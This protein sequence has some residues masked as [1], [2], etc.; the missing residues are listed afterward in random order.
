MQLVYAERLSSDQGVSRANLRVAKATDTYILAGRGSKLGTLGGEETYEPHFTYHGF[1]YVELVAS[2]NVHVESLIGIAVRTA[3]GE[4]TDL[5]TSD[6]RVNRLWQIVKWSLRANLMSVPTD[7]PQRS[8]R[9]GWL[10][11]AG[12]FWPTAVYL[13]DLKEF[14]R[15]WAQDLRDA[16]QGLRDAAAEGTIEGNVPDRAAFGCYPPFAPPPIAECGGPGWSDAGV[17]VPYAS[18]LQYGDAT[19]LRQHWASMQSYM[20]FIAKANP[21]FTWIEDNRGYGDWRAPFDEP[22]A[23]AVIGTA[24]WAADALAMRTMAH[25]LG[26]GRDEAIYAR[27]YERIRRAFGRAYVQPDGRVGEPPTIRDRKSK[28]RSSQTNDVLAL[29]YGLVPERMR[30]R[31]IE[32]LVADVESRGD[33]LAT[34]YLGTP[35]LLPVLSDSGRDDLAYK[36]LLQTER[37]SWLYVVEHG[38]TTMWEAW[39]ANTDTKAS[40]NHCI[41]GSVG[42]WLVRYAAGITQSASS[43]GFQQI[44]VH[45]HLDPGS[46]LA[47]LSATY[48]SAAGAIE[49]A[50]SV[51]ENHAVRLVVTI[52]RSSV[53]RVDLPVWNG[54]EYK[55]ISYTVSSGEHVFTSRPRDERHLAKTHGAVPAARH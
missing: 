3:V 32:N 35:Q 11:D 34:G 44:L 13:T 30:R 46:H 5:T 19:L 4:T 8:E 54:S 55:Y 53:A 1:R 20:S 21:N 43:I 47:R 33:R 49:S 6:P 36:L 18:Y 39:D 25:D 29:R 48:R 50:W 31:V 12:G 24:F 40:L 38:A 15:K 28:A 27:T 22:V 42:F 51:S 14:T 45:P 26:D 41:L 17:L 16:Q 2:D 7:S 10:G 37:P 52:P 23:P 9:F